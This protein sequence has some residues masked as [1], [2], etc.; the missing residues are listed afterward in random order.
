MRSVKIL[1]CCLL[2]VSAC[3]PQEESPAET[4]SSAVLFEGAR[5]IVGDGSE[6]LEN[7]AFLV[8]NGRFTQVGA[9]GEIPLPA[10][11][12]RM[13]LTGKTVM[14]AIVDAHKHVANTREDL[15][16]LLEQFA[17]FG[18]GAVLSLGLDGGD[19]AFQMQGETIPGAARMRTAGPG[20]T[21]PEPGRS[22]VPHWVTSEE[23]ARAAV[24][25]LAGQQV[26]WIK[27]WVDDRNG[28]YE[29]LSAPLYG[30]VIDEA[31]SNDLTVAAHIFALEDA[32]GLLE[33]GIDAFAH[34]VRDRDVDDEFVAMIQERPDVFL[35]P[36]LPGRGVADDMSW[37]SG[38]L[39]AEEV[40][41]LQAAST[42][43]P[44][45]QESFGIQAVTWTG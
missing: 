14:P 21:A 1:L 2:L 22:E 24:Q 5:L 23:E 10:G 30:A 31:H 40:E 27:I 42:D 45:A 43:R 44:A 9:A 37:L 19:L 35:I 25:E 8:E 39:P 7:S 18:V 20:I 16:D 17:Y 12:A 4:L 28:Q 34:S 32:K 13:D 6:P 26:D 29:K 33:A 38:S 11:A 15:V 41:R 3:S 36:N